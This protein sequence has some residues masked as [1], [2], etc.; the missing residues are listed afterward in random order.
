MTTTTTTTTCASQVAAMLHDGSHEQRPCRLDTGHHGVCKYDPPTWHDCPDWCVL[1]TDHD[2][3]WLL[4]GDDDAMHDGPSF[5]HVRT[6]S[7]SRG[8]FVEVPDLEFG[9]EHGEATSA[10][11][12]RA[13]LDLAADLTA[14]AQWVA[15]R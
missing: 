3:K 12:A 15:Q 4:G 10:D 9:V 7:T 2:A 11:L 6:G 13:L 1:P 8:L 14:C 5:G